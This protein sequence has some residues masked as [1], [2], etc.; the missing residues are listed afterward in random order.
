MEEMKESIMQNNIHEVLDYWYDIK[1]LL[2][3]EIQ[4]ISNVLQKEM[5]EIFYG[6]NLPAL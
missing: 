6:S 3:E 5:V 2:E 4:S 1:D